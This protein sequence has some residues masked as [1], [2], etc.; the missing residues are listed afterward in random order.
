MKK[1]KLIFIAVIVISA[2]A[3]FYF[4]IQTLKEQLDDYV[5]EDSFDD[6]AD[7]DF[8]DD[9]ISEE[10]DVTAKEEKPTKTASKIRRGYIPIKLHKNEASA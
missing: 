6:D 4:L 10:S 3:G 1:S 7:L 9:E 8:L 5:E 2:L